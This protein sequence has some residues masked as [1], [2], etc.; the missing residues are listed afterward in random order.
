M[1]ALV[2]VLDDWM[3]AMDRGEYT[4]AIFVDL[5][6]AFDTVDHKVLLKKLF[7]IGV[8]GLTLKWFEN[9]LI[10]RRIVTKVN[11][12]I[13]EEKHLTHGVPQGSILGPLLFCIFY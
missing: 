5:K 9:Y 12:S 13:S 7:D 1:T 6:K 11:N 8:R 3:M 4:G 2:I 10:N